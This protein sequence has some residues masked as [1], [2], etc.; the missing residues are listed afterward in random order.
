MAETRKENE[1]DDNE[2]ENDKISKD[3]KWPRTT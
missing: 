3:R 2:N 1:K